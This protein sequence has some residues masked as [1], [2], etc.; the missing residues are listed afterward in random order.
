M[1]DDVPPSGD[2]ALMANDGGG[3]CQTTATPNLF[4]VVLALLAFRPR[5]R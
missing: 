4:A 5:K 1:N 3:C 2:G